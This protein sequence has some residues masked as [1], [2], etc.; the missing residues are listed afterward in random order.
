VWSG[1]VLLF[2]IM[3]LVI[4]GPLSLS[5]SSSLVVAPAELTLR[6]YRQVFSRPEWLAAFRLSAGIALATT[7][8][9]TSLGV[10]LAMA[11]VRGRFRFKSAVYVLVLAPMMVP[12]MITAVALYFLFSSLD[13]IGSPVAMTLGHTVIALPVATIILAATLQGFDERLERTAISLGASPLTAFRRITLPLVAPGVVSAALFSFLTSF[14]ELLVSLFLAT[15]TVRT[16]PV[17]IWSALLFEI[18]PSVA[19]VSTTL[20]G[21]TVLILGLSQLIRRRPGG[22]SPPA[23]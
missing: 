1:A 2:L 19:A 14:D 22:W 10:T 21:V 7:V 4:I 16:L 18:E 17:R 23:G 12:V 15:P 6:W 11:L 13:M 3:P 8:L 9:A 20:I 5:P